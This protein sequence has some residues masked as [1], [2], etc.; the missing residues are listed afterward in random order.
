MK[1]V[2]SLGQK[3]ANAATKLGIPQASLRALIKQRGK[4]LHADRGERKRQHPGKAPG[5]EAA[6]VKWI[7]DAR[8]GN[9]PL[10]GEGRDISSKLPTKSFIGF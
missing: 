5:F 6:L 9:A 7:D 2:V 3:W 4:V 8:S 10:S 1:N